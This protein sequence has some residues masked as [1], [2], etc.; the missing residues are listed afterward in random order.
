MA[1][2]PDN[3]ELLLIDLLLG[4]CDAAAAA[5]LRRRLNDDPQLRARRDDIANALS[6]VQ[7]APQAEPPEPPTGEEV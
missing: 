6:A 5:E 4:R 1:N 3:D 2:A 7:L